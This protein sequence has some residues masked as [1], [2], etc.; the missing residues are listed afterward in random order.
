MKWRILR[1]N[2]HLDILAGFF[3]SSSE[4]TIKQILDTDNNPKH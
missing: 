1:N 4:Y 2:A 3:R